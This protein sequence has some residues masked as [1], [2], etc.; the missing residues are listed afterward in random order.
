MLYN[1][2]ERI[3]R[4]KWIERLESCVA[5]IEQNLFGNIDMDVLAS[6]ACLSKLYF[7]RMFL[8]VTGVPIS[9]YIRRRRMTVAA[10]RLVNTGCKVID[11]AL[12]LGYLSP[13]AFSRA[14]KGVHGIA[15]AEAASGS[16]SLKAYPPISFQIKVKG[17]AAM[18][19]TIIK[20]DAFHLLGVVRRFSTKDGE[21][22][23]KIPEFWAEFNRESCSMLWPCACREQIFGA[24]INYDP[25]SEEFDY[26]IGVPFEG[27]KPGQFEMIQIP[28]AT[29]AI[30]K[31]TGAMPHALQ[32]TMQRIY[33]EWL[34]A[35][36]YELADAPHME[37]YYDGDITA[38][39]Y[40]SEIWMPLLGLPY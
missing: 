4:M 39:D 22:L 6:K 23:R 14:F 20:K 29:W 33:S 37:L 9:E 10:N 25:K 28:A 36:N 11:L 8:Y 30:F 16:H 40:R 32:N 24:S 1:D 5:Y 13:E 17:E 7:Y 19:Y 27:E 31:I 2:S 26:V 12:A 3:M 21:S 38:D 18:N 15:P 34:P 35:T